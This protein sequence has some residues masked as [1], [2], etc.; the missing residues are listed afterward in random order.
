[1][2][3]VSGSAVQGLEGA[4]LRPAR[5]P[6][7]RGF[8]LLNQL[9]L[10]PGE[11][12]FQGRKNSKR[13]S[14]SGGKSSELRRNRG[15]RRWRCRGEAGGQGGRGEGE[16]EEGTGDGGIPKREAEG[17]KVGCERAVTASQLER[18]WPCPPCRPCHPVWSQLH[19]IASQEGRSATNDKEHEMNTWSLSSSTSSNFDKKQNLLWKRSTLKT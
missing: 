10:E 15:Q 3:Q 17:R 4:A 13:R 19:S 16:E 2:R 9:I 8:S 1:M 12:H 5:L 6:G 7:P 11:R 14:S 18:V